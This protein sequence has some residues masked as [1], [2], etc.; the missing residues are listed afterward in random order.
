MSITLMADSI[1]ELRWLDW[2]MVKINGLQY[3]L[4]NPKG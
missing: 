1:D 4:M 2:Q 3:F